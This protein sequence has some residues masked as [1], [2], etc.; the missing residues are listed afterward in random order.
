MPEVKEASLESF[1]E[2]VRSRGNLRT[3][4][5]AQRWTSAVLRSLALN[6]GRVARNDLSQAL[7]EPLRDQLKRQFWLLHFRDRSLTQHEFLQ[8]VAR[9]S[10]N[11]DPQFSRLATSGVFAGLKSLI[12]S[13]VSDEVADSLSPEVS[14]LWQSA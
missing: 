9:R 12:D 5:H 11:T 4:T 1:Y 7:P 2:I 13:D 14:A 10:G 6:L 8:Q 3:E